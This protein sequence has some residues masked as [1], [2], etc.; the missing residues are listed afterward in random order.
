LDDLISADK[1]FVGNSL[2]GLISAD[3]TG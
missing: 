2:R 1:I 3:L